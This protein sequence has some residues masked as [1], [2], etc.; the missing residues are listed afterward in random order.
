MLQMMQFET[1]KAAHFEVKIASHAFKT[2]TMR[3]SSN[4]YAFLYVTSKLFESV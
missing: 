2:N 3:M 1:Q 4:F